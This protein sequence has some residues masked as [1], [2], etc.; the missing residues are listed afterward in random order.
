MSDYLMKIGTDDDDIK[1]EVRAIEIVSLI[2]HPNDGTY[3][4]VASENYAVIKGGVLVDVVTDQVPEAIAIAGQ[5][6]D[7]QEQRPRY[8]YAIYLE[9]KQHGN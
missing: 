6:F 3:V 5:Y 1:L 2:D 7:A 8:P 9:D 4:K